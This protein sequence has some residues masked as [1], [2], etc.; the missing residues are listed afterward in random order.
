MKNRNVT[1][2]SLPKT[3]PALLAATT[4]EDE[5]AGAFTPMIVRFDS[6]PEPGDLV[7]DSTVPHGLSASIGAMR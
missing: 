1:M 3:S 4:S 6:S 2:V 7:I 5:S